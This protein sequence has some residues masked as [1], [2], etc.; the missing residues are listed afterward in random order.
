MAR[1]AT[2]VAQGPLVSDAANADA[3]TEF[4]QILD[5][6]NFSGA[7]V[8][9]ALGT[10]VTPG[11]F[12][13]RD[14]LP[15]YLRRVV[16]PTAINTLVKLFVLDQWVDET[17]VRAAVAPLDIVDLCALGL[18]ENDT[19]GV[20][21][22]VRLSG[23]R[24]LVLAHDRYDEHAPSLSHD[25]V[26]D[27][28]P[29]TVTLTNL[30]VQRPARTALDI[31]TGCGVL[32]LLLAAHSE[33]VVAIDTNPRALSFAAFNARLNGRAHVVECRLGSLFEPVAGERFDL[34]ACNPPYVISPD[35]RYI[36]RDGG[37][38]GD[39][40]CAEIARS[41][42]EHLENGGF[43]SMLCNWGLPAG[44]RDWSAPVRAWVEGTGCDAW[45]LHGSTQDPLAYAALWNRSRDAGAYA[46]ALD[47]WTAYFD[48]LGFASLAHGAI[49][50]RRRDST[51]TWVRADKLPDGPLDLGS[52][53]IQRIFETETYLSSVPDDRALLQVAFRTTTDHR[54]D[55]QWA[56]RD[57][58]YALE[59]A[60]VE[61]D[62]GLRFQGT[63]DPYTTHLLARCNGRRTLGAIAAELTE[64]GGLAGDKAEA[65]CAAVARKLASLGF[66]IPVGSI[67]RS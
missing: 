62:A 59:Y 32:A 40:L 15:L 36:F 13:Y 10:P 26:L 42:P 41:M 27:V 37:R 21:G 54:L 51:H 2:R 48:E 58:E 53:H 57:G 49:V 43:A 66:L 11:R 22:R 60:A 4:K 34:I 33:R 45:L 38:R 35:S 67:R 6:V 24:D 19:R 44:E 39:A 52:A 23:Y 1:T 65:S 50:M 9:T 3:I 5:R 47:R 29:T 12:H 8:P 14:D 55:Q 18:V 30:L 25:Y 28:N 64:K 17:A 7:G 56:L 16:A 46:A 20:H 61:L 31:G 63:V